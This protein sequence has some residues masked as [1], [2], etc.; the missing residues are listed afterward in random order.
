[1]KEIM[2]YAIHEAEGQDVTMQHDIA[3]SLVTGGANPDRDIL[4]Y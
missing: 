1:M 4:A 2:I 3:Y